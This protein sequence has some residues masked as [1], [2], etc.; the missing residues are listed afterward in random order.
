MSHYETLSVPKTA[1]HAE[2]EAAFEKLRQVYSA[3]VHPDPSRATESLKRVLK[4]YRVLRDPVQRKEY[5][6]ILEW[7]ESPLEGGAISDE[8][9]HSWL[10]EGKVS[11]GIKSKIEA[12]R[13][14]RRSEFV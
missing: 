3:E 9:F 4:A 12:D 13:V 14:L 7:Q 10:A 1:S 8:E 6:G 5:D 2:I 11:E